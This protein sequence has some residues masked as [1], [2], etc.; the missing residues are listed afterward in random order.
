MFDIHNSL[1]VTVRDCIF[2]NNTGTGIVNE[3]YRGNTGGLSITYNRIDKSGSNP[4]INI[5]NCNFTN[6]SAIPKNDLSS[7]QTFGVGVLKGRGG[8]MGVFVREDYFNISAQISHCNFSY[9]SVKSFG[10]GMYIL[11]NGKG[12]HETMVEHSTFLS[13]MAKSGGAGLILVGADEAKYGPHVF[14]VRQCQFKDNRAAIGGGL[15]YSINLGNGATSVVHIEES[16]FVGNDLLDAY[17][18]FGAALVFD[19]AEDFGALESFHMNSIK[20]W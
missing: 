17:V 13:N 3:Q 9:N 20:D 11:F 19:I 18:K 4:V 7:D 5:T 15:Y 1:S 10:G 14:T 8:G 12:S 6:N 16:M 2:I